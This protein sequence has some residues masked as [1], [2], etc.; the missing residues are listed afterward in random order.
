[1]ALQGGYALRPQTPG[2]LEYASPAQIAEVPDELDGVGAY[3]AL[4]GTVLFA[5]ASA[6]NWKGP[7]L[8]LL[9]LLWL[10]PIVLLARAGRRI[11]YLPHAVV[12]TM[13]IAIHWIG[14]DNLD[15]LLRA[16][17]N[18]ARDMTWPLLNLALL[19]GL[20]LAAAIA[21]ELRISPPRD[22]DVQTA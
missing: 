5:A 4:V 6:L 8:T 21:L 13:L 11:G 17:D 14:A 22:R 10:A 16:W 12:L 20:L 1:I 2:V 15:P 18:P 19:D 9:A 7:Q 3:L